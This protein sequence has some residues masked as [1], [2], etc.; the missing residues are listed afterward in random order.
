MNTPLNVTERHLLGFILACLEKRVY[1]SRS[2]IARTMAERG[3]GPVATADAVEGLARRRLV[4]FF[5][6]PD[7]PSVDRVRGVG[8]G[9]QILAG[10]H[11]EDLRKARQAEATRTSQLQG[12]G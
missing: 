9:G 5:E 3:V 6:G 1:P 8:A 2:L 4:S 12:V 11:A 7:G 10:P